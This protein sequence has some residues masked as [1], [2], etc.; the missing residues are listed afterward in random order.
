[1]RTTRMTL[2][3]ALLIP[4]QTYTMP[5]RPPPARV[6]RERASF[7][8]TA[9]AS[10]L[11]SFQPLLADR[12]AACN[13]NRQW[14]PW[15]KQAVVVLDDVLGESACKRLRLQA[16]AIRA[17]GMLEDCESSGAVRATQCAQG[18]D[19]MRAA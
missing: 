8:I 6:A 12:L 1:M 17:G 18:N 11:A 5:L 2:L 16:E 3:L 14:S 4:R 10:I 15:G 7:S 19:E 9:E 13:P